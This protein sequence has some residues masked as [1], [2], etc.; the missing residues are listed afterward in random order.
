VW[1]CSIG[2]RGK[3][4]STIMESYLYYSEYPNIIIRVIY[5]YIQSSAR[6]SREIHN[7][8]LLHCKT[9]QPLAVNLLSIF[10]GRLLIHVVK[11]KIYTNIFAV[12]TR[13][14]L[15]YTIYVHKQCTS[16]HFVVLLYV[17]L[18]DWNFVRYN[19]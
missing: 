12:F 6:H 3:H 19:N 15:H 13:L 5:K 17:S 10:R 14:K 7:I 9:P 16:Y 8:M 2:V 4:R 18:Q 11:M 1:H